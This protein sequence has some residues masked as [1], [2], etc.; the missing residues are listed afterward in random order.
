[1]GAGKLLFSQLPLNVAALCGWGWALFVVL[2]RFRTGE[3]WPEHFFSVVTALESICWFEVIQIALGVSHGNLTLGIVLHT[4]RMLWLLV[5]C[6]RIQV[7]ALLFGNI[8]N[9][10]ADLVLLAW[11]LTEVARYP[12]F[13][14]PQSH[15]VSAAPMP[16]LPT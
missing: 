1:M 10:V 13:I 16:H 7:V 9:L 11:C 6:P 4:I 12:M 8:G 5:V 14:F 15:L 2:M 3:P